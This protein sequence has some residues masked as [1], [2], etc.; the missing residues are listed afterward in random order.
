[1]GIWMFTVGAAIVLTM[2]SLRG[3]LVALP[4]LVVCALVIRHGWRKARARIV[5][6][7]GDPMNRARRLN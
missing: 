5:A 7:E 2:L 1:M 4:L 6:E 3:Q